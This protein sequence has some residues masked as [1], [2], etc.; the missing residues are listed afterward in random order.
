MANSPRLRRH[1]TLPSLVYFTCDAIVTY[2]SSTMTFSGSVPWRSASIPAMA[3][4]S[5][6]YP[7]GRSHSVSPWHQAPHNQIPGNMHYPG[8]PLPMVG[9]MPGLSS[10]NHHMGASPHHSHRPYFHHP[11]GP[12]PHSKR[13][14]KCNEC[15]QAF[16]RNHDLKR[17]QRIHLVIKSF[18]CGDYEKRFSRTDALKVSWENRETRSPQ[19]FGSLPHL[20]VR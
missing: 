18:A 14:F 5:L 1:K 3:L 20:Q 4:P 8:A 2:T 17:H 6:Q 11:G 10:Y 9:G 15:T 12:P 7:G 19:C 16:N 13:P